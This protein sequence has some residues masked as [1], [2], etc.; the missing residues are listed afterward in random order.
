M[1]GRAKPL[2]FSA[3][4]AIVGIGLMPHGAMAQA[5]PVDP[6]IEE[7]I[8]PLRSM[9]E[10]DLVPIGASCGQLGFAPLLI[11]LPL[12]LLMGLYSSKS[13]PKNTF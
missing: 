5:V 6:V 11:G 4:V 9:D 1:T 12:L 10:V 8:R 3:L 7:P 2:I 13:T